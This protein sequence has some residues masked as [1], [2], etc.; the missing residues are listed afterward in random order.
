MKDWIISIVAVVL[1]T[2]IVCLILPQGKM[3]KYV[4]G[5]FSLLSTLVVI[6][7]I[8]YIKNT[9]V[10][11]EQI[12]NSNELVL[13]DSFIDYVTNKRIEEFK[14]NCLKITKENGADNAKVEIEYFLDENK[15]IKICFVKISLQ[16]SVI[17]SDK[18]HINFKEEIISD[19]ASYLCINENMVIIYEWK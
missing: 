19:I 8:F 14:E 15:G 17:I 6:K 9:D 16:N 2:S 11:F 13:Q 12:F 5:I 10:N 4:K 1:I 18:E 3:G 7:P